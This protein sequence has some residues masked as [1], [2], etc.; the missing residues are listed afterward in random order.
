MIYGF[1]LLYSPEMFNRMMRVCTIDSIHNNRVS[2]SPRRT[3]RHV[4]RFID[5]Y[6]SIV[7]LWVIRCPRG[8]IA[9]MSGFVVSIFMLYEN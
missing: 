7:L 4:D 3:V 2:A 5:F 1:I 8:L 6:Q 9:W